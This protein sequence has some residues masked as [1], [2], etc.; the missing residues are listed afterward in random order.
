MGK[1]LEQLFEQKLLLMPKEVSVFINF[2]T[3]GAFCW[4][5]RGRYV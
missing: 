4:K 1:T 2:Y 5:F 3:E